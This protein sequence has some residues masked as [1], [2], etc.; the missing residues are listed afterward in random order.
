MDLVSSCGLWCERFYNASYLP[1][2]ISYNYD[3]KPRSQAQKSSL[4][5][6]S[7]SLME[8]EN[9]YFIQYV[10]KEYLLC[11]QHCPGI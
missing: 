2:P 5:S 4:S 10:V 9:L 11:A 1:T 6:S 8:S 7:R 3:L